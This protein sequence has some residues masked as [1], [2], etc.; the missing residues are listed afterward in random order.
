MEGPD[1]LSTFGVTVCHTE[2]LR[3]VEMELFLYTLCVPRIDLELQG[4]VVETVTL[5]S[6]I[7]LRLETCN[8]INNQY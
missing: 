6:F 5:W 3:Y 4:R 2:A 1:S 7:C 8:A